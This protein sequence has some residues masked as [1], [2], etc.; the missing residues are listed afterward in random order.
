VNWFS[1]LKN[2]V[3]TQRQGFR[4]DDE[5]EDYVL[6]DDEDCYEKLV[7]FLENRFTHNFKSRSRLAYSKN[8]VSPR[9]PVNPNKPSE[10]LWLYNKSTIP[11][12]I[13][14][15][16]LEALKAIISHMPEIDWTKPQP[17]PASSVPYHPKLD[18]SHSAET[19]GS[20]KK[21]VEYF[22]TYKE[23][24]GDFHEIMYY[25]ISEPSTM[26]DD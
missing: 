26:E 7:S 9:G 1:L 14:C 12:E 13:Y 11:D 20:S 5:D 23:K 4:L 18:I 16:V 25:S 22:I 19:L 2:Q 15:L 3:Q 6:E 17:P 24:I 10:Y 8:L 21:V